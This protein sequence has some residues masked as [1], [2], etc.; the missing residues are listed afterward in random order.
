[1]RPHILCSL[2]ISITSACRTS[3]TFIFSLSLHHI[4]SASDPLFHSPAFSLPPSL[5]SPSFTLPRWYLVAAEQEAREQTAGEPALILSCAICCG[6]VTV[7]QTHSSAMMPHHSWHIY[8]SGLK[9]EQ[10]RRNS[11]DEKKP[12]QQS[13]LRMFFKIWSEAQVFVLTF[14][15]QANL[16]LAKKTSSNR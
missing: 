10:E 14:T 15:H 16:R 8:Q 3:S 11:P 7:Q 5:P 4:I 13:T 2:F 9:T 6:H 1:M 12:W